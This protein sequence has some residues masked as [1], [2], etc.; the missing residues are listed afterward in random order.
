MNS[1][2]K[3]VLSLSV[4]GSMLFLVVMG[5]TRLGQNRLSKAWQYYAWLLV[6]ARLLAPITTSVSLVGTIFAQP[7]AALMSQSMPVYQTLQ[8]SHTALVSSGAAIASQTAEGLGQISQKG[9][10][11]AEQWLWVAWIA[12]VVLLAVYKGIKYRRFVSYICAEHAAVSDSDLLNRLGSICEE[13]GIHQKIDLYENEQVPSPLVV[14]FLKPRIVLPSTK[15][16][17]SEFRY[18]ML[19]ELTH[20]RRGDQLYKWLMQLILCIHW[21][22]P[23]VYWMARKV[24]RACELSCDEAVIRRLDADAKYEYGSL[25]IHSLNHPGKN[26]QILWGSALQEDAMAVKERL[27]AIM[28]YQKKSKAMTITAIVLS[29][30]LAMGGVG[31]GVFVPDSAMAADTQAT[32]GESLR[33]IQD[34][35]RMTLGGKDIFAYT[36]GELYALWNTFDV[37]EGASIGYSGYGGEAPEEDPLGLHFPIDAAI[38]IMTYANEAD[39]SKSRE[40]L[41][42]TPLEETNYSVAWVQMIDTGVAGPFGIEVGM[43]VA[44]LQSLLPEASKTDLNV[45]EQGFDAVYTARYREE[46]GATYTIQA[47]SVMDMVSYC[48]ITRNY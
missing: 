28:T 37:P 15:L 44:T 23:L 7:S 24:N 33:I 2:M 30:F 47:Y 17:E 40:E 20:F 3:V 35:E 14:G 39:T 18:V 29:A 46:S 42:S 38:T 8:G 10:A 4:S 11:D 31:L 19:H 5:I 36:S 34:E 26:R 1:L 6:A 32:A 21:F 27:E 41:L 45:D 13:L 16:S 9:L 25:L 22:N 48:T 12:M 43:T